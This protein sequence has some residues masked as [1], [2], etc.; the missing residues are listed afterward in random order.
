[1]IT[2]YNGFS[3]I[4]QYKKFK[5]SDLELV[6]RDLLNHFSIRKGEKLMNSEF[7]S[8]IWSMLFEPLTPET[9]AIIV[10][11]IQRIASYDPRIKL[12]NIIL[13]QFENGIQIEC[14]ITVLPDNISDMLVMRFDKES[15]IISST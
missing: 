7:G 10:E 14:E 11:D 3:T 8:I 5:V 12:D 15:N 13:D 2:R 9:R 4:D 6:K 1:M